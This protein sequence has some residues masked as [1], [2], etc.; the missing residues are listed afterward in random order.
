M[1]EEFRN[2]DL[3]TAKELG[4]INESLKWLVSGY[5]G[6]KLEQAALRETIDKKFFDLP[7]QRLGRK[8]YGII[9]GTGIVA[10]LAFFK[11]NIVKFLG[12]LLN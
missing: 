2:F 12:N 8:Y 7:C 9:G 1:N 3:Q 5:E 4:K 11:T 10:I 6:V